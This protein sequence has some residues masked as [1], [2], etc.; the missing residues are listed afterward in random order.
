MYSGLLNCFFDKDIPLKLFKSLI[1]LDIDIICLHKK[2]DLK[3]IDTIDFK[4]S[5]HIYEEIDQDKPFEDTIAIINNIDLLLTVDTCTTYL[6]GIMGK[7]T[8]L[9]SDYYSD[10]RWFNYSDDRVPWYKD[11]KIVKM[12]KPNNWPF[13]INSLKE[14]ITEKLRKRKVDDATVDDATVDDATVEMQQ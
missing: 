1:D 14:R 4:D 2:D 7:D 5:L 12:D 13:V 11:V 3:G 6:G 9:M 8:L 10:W